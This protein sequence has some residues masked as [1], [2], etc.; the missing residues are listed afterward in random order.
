MFGLVPDI[1]TSDE[2]CC[3]TMCNQS[4]KLVETLG[5]IFG[6]TANAQK[7]GGPQLQ[8]LSV[9]IDNSYISS[10][11]IAKGTGSCLSQDIMVLQGAEGKF[12]PS[13]A[14]FASPFQTFRFIFRATSLGHKPDLN[15]QAWVVWLY[16]HL[17]SGLSSGQLIGLGFIPSPK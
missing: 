7:M 13:S 3:A 6:V 17:T 4:V 1:P 2:G 5:Q 8:V 12:L 15:G 16:S 9:M 14:S 10:C 11:F